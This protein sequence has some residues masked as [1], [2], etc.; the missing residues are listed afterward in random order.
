MLCPVPRRDTHPWTFKANVTHG[1]ELVNIGTVGGCEPSRGDVRL[2]RPYYSPFYVPD[3]HRI[4]LKV[5]L[6]EP[7]PQC[8]AIK[9]LYWRPGTARRF[10]TVGQLRVARF[11][12]N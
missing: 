3:T 10:E 5:E 1:R 4:V 12:K 9:Q 7:T 6:R 11:S 2:F 8:V